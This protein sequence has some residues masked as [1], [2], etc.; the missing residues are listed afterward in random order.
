MGFSIHGISAD[1]EAGW[2]VAGGSDV[3]GDGLLDLVIGAPSAY[4]GVDRTG[5]AY[6]VY[7]KKT[8][9]S[10]QLSDI[11]TGN[12][13]FVIKG[14]ASSEQSGRS[15]SNAGDVNGDGLDD[16]LIG[17]H[18]NDDGGADAGKAYLMLSSS[19]TPG[20]MSLANADYSFIGEESGDRAGKFVLIIEDIDGD[21]TDELLISAP[22]SDEN[23]IDSGNPSADSGKLLI[24]SLQKLSLIPRTGR[25]F[26]KLD[27]R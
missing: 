7:G 3:N 18:G 1:D 22:Y 14:N 9:N 10:I 23:G 24:L 13:G 2:D 26:L 25:S 5:A 8:T 6:V 21:G 12:G 15:V 17:A 19:L 4:N 27:F 20:T 11:A 16:I